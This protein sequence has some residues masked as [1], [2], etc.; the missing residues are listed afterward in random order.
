MSDHQLDK[1]LGIFQQIDRDPILEYL[2]KKGDQWTEISKTVMLNSST[3][4]KDMQIR[5]L[6]N[7][8][9]NFF[10]EDDP[11]DRTLVEIF[12]NNQETLGEEFFQKHVSRGQKAEI[13]MSMLDPAQRGQVIETLRLEDVSP[14]WGVLSKERRMDCWANFSDELKFN[15]MV[16]EKYMSEDQK[17]RLWDNIGK[18]KR[19]EMWRLCKEAHCYEKN[20]GET[21]NEEFMTIA[22]KI[23]QLQQLLFG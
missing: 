21:A 6:I 22:R 1:L 20:W 18:E 19:L 12:R 15:F 10:N 11:N 23:Q 13:L 17:R 5:R 16:T 8:Q 9:Q 4:T 3:E 14:F 7:K 2:L